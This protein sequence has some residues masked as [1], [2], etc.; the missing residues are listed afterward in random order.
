MYS[1]SVPED[2]ALHAATRDS[3]LE[4]VGAIPWG[5]HFCQFYTSKEDLLE[6]LVPYMKAGLEANEFCLWLTS[7]ALD[8]REAEAA[9]RRAVPEL[10]RYLAEQRIE[11]AECGQ[12]YLEGGHFDANKALK[13][14]LEMADSA[15]KRGFEGLRAA[16]SGTL[17]W[18]EQEDLG[19]FIVYESDLDRAVNSLRVLVLCPYSLEQCGPREIVDAA[20]NHEFALIRG[21]KGW[22]VLENTAR[23]RIEREFKKF[24]SLAGQQLGIHRHLR[25][26]FRAVLHQRGWA[27]HGWARR[28]CPTQGGLYQGSLFSRGPKAYPRRLP[29][30]ESSPKGGRKRSS[31]SATSKRGRPYG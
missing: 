3:G 16:G 15:L 21:A 28:S 2:S 26:G 12:W 6:T 23:R 10:D 4:A 17:G 13:R 5:T 27:P 1:L 25:H 29:A 8:A 20:A 30:A 24:V 31:A 7:P 14:A 11:F 9:L 18:L 22:Q 19:K